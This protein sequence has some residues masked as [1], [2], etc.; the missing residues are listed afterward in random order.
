MLNYFTTYLLLYDII[1]I[2][3]LQLHFPTC[4]S[5]QF[6]KMRKDSKGIAVFFGY[7]Q[8]GQILRNVFWRTMLQTMVLLNLDSI[9]F[10]IVFTLFG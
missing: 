7:E 6:L 2:Y 10:Q 1:F 4:L 8:L 5:F 9:K 3:T